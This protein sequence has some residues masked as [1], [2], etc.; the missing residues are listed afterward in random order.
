RISIAYGNK[1]HAFVA[2]AMQHGLHDHQGVFNNRL[3]SVLEH[4]I[5]RYRLVWPADTTPFRHPIRVGQKARIHDEIS[6][7]RRAMFETKGLYGHM[8]LVAAHRTNGSFDSA[9]QVMNR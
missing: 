3:R 8:L 6:I 5:V 9:A 4:D 2:V 7:Q 1:V